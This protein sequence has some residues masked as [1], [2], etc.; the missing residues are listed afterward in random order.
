[1]PK[2]INQ[3]EKENYYMVSYILECK[4]QCGGSYSKGGKAEWEVLRGRDKP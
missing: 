1:M 3:S 4:K 2:E